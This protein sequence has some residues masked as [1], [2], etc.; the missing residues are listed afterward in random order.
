M[1]F[2]FYENAFSMMREVYAAWD[3]PP[4]CPL[5]DFDRAFLPHSY[6]PIGFRSADGKAHPHDVTWPVNEDEPGRGQVRMTPWGAVTQLLSLCRRAIEALIDRPLG[7]RTWTPSAGALRAM[8]RLQERGRD[9][10]DRPA[11]LGAWRG[12]LRLLDKAL[13]RRARALTSRN[14]DEHPVIALLDLIL[15]LLTAMVD[16]DEGV[17]HDWDFDRWNH[18]ELRQLLKKHGGHPAV[19]DHWSGLR[20]IYDST[21]Q[22][23][24][25]D[26]K[27]PDMAAGTGARVVLRTMT[28]YKGSVLYHLAAGAGETF[29][30]PL[31]EVLKQR[32]VRFEMFHDVRELTCSEG[33]V[34]SVR[35]A[36]QADAQDYRPTFVHRGL[37]V[38][39]EEPFWDQLGGK[40]SGDF[41]RRWNKPE[42]VDELVLRDGPD[43]DELI[44]AIPLGAIRERK[45]ADELRVHEPFAR[46][47]DAPSLVP[48]AAAQLWMD[49]SLLELG[50]IRPPPALVGWT[51]PLSIWADHRGESIELLVDGDLQLADDLEVRFTPGHTAGSH[52]LRAGDVLFTGDHLAWS[53]ARQ[54]LIAFR[55]A[56]WDSWPRQ[57]GSMRTLSGVEVRHVLPAHGAPAFDLQPGAIDACIAWME[58]A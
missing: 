2:G 27:Q 39:P 52:C 22:Y 37:V 20:M 10:G 33:R 48:T 9:L 24:Q 38:W 14:V 36:V 28:T 54:H 47:L 40:F 26:P 50:W 58:G 12:L 17:A 5:T 57:I 3:P 42:P 44:L 49:E 53:R 13:D 18:M 29:I 56:C 32:G 11:D 19:V 6:T 15:A 55:D 30:S 45:L 1:W 4:G 7:D 31:Y 46:M 21:S 43:Y 51:Y 34:D 23:R 16:P 41:E 25:G 35:I 8:S